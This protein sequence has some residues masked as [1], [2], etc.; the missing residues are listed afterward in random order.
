[1]STA[2]KLLRIERL[3]SCCSELR[4]SFSRG[5]ASLPLQALVWTEMK[6]KGRGS[7]LRLPTPGATCGPL[8]M[9]L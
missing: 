7:C 6:V 2:E 9:G 3:F 8:R 5:S 4:L 1:M